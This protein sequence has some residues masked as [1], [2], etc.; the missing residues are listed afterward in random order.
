M[1]LNAGAINH[2]FT[3]RSRRAFI[4]N[5][6]C[7]VGV[8]FTAP[9]GVLSLFKGNLLVG[10]SLLT[11]AT[12]YTLNHLY[13]RSTRN[14]LFSA[15]VILYPLYALML[16]LVYSGGVNG[17][18]HV[19]IYCIPPVSLFLHGLKRGLL[20]V[21]L[22]IC[23]L[24]L[25]LFYMD[26]PFNDLDYHPDLKSRIIYSFILIAFLST[27]YEYISSRFNQ[28]LQEL[29]AKLELAATTDP[30][31][32]LLNRR[33][34][35]Q[36]LEQQAWDAPAV[37]LM[38][39]DHFKRINDEFGHEYGDEYLQ[40]VAYS[41]EGLLSKYSCLISRWGGEE[42]MV[43]LEHPASM[44]DVAE[45]LRRG[46][47]SAVLTTSLGAN[48]STTISIGVTEAKVGESV[49]RALGRADKALYEAKDNGRNKV[50][51]AQKESP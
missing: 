19:W 7:L 50:V 13:L 21:F 8:L 26:S 38:D 11:I 20:E 33:G 49:I 5:L 44:K 45:L 36:Q 1:T 6:F 2:S 47:A 28:S 10:S 34:M 25:I 32:G 39:V 23:A 31:T 9:L 46:I 51:I 15:N 12:I 4:I 3:N 24:A 35:E 42:F 41:L 30:L 48:I 43:V 27:I 16:Y 40:R 17:T 14:Y 22:F 29:S 37:L 18:G